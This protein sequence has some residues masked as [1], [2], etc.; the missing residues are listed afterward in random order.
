MYGGWCF[1]CV[2]LCMRV[3]VCVVLPS[4]NNRSEIRKNTKKVIDN[5]THTRTREPSASE[6]AHSVI[7]WLQPKVLTHKML[8]WRG[9]ES[10]R[11]R[12]IDRLVAMAPP[13]AAKT[14]RTLAS[15]HTHP[16][17]LSHTHAD[18]SAASLVRA[19]IRRRRRQT[20]I[21]TRKITA[22]ARSHAQIFIKS[23]LAKRALG[24]YLIALCL[25]N[26]CICAVGW[27]VRPAY[28]L[29]WHSKHNKLWILPFY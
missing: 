3:R 18:R 21:Y 28:F 4:N 11:W 2:S 13:A 23:S 20:N 15:T 5:K 24:M 14:L 22:R 27:C 7:R 17:T 10:D 26:V 8:D 19:H 12:D 9:V 1:F 6:H 16:A 29:W 25:N